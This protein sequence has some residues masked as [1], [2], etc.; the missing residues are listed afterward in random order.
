MDPRKP[1]LHHLVVN[2]KCPGEY[3]EWLLMADVCCEQFFLKPW[4]FAV[5][6]LFTARLLARGFYVL[7]YVRNSYYS[8]IYI[9]YIYIYIFFWFPYEATNQP[10]Q[11]NQP[12]WVA[13]VTILHISDTHGQHR[14]MSQVT[15]APF[16]TRKK[17]AWFVYRFGPRPSIQN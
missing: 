8:V 16:A 10:N 5:N 4:L 2:A 11:P 12:V 6:P 15:V 7:C 3:W 1:K 9:M 14:E 17:M 13:E